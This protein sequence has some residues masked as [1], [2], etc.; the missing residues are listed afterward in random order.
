ML[1]AVLVIQ[2]QILVFIPQ[3]QLTVILIIVYAQF[4]SYHLLVPLIV[5]YVL[6]DNLIMASFSLMYTP[7]MMIMWVVLGVVA[8]MLRHKPDFVL[9]IWAVGFAFLYSWSFI[10]ARL[11]EQSTM[12]VWLYLKADFVFEI[13]LAANSVITFQLFYEP[14]KRLFQRIYRRYPKSMD[15]F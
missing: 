14:L 3:V 8:R 15:S 12:N 2:E 7:S 13:I 9:F 11:I 4:L 5:G 6:L 10:P 1:L